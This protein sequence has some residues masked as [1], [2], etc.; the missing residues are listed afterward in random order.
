MD[1]ELD[2]IDIET[3]L[4][5]VEYSKDRIRNY[6]GN[7]YEQRLEKLRRLDNAAAKL[8]AARKLL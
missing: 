4:E 6:S 5:S 7:T 8:R 1:V 2:G 3:L